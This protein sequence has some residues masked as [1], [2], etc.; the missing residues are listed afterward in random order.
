MEE[1]LA[2]QAKPAVFARLLQA[3][4]DER[5]S[6]VSLL[7]AGLD[8][9]FTASL[10]ADAVADACYAFLRETK[11][12][13]ATLPE[14][15]PDGSAELF[16]QQIKDYEAETQQKRDA[17]LLGKAELTTVCRCRP[18]LHQWEG[19]AAPRQRRRYAGGVRP[20]ARPV[21]RTGRPARGHAKD[22][23]RCAGSRLRLYG[24]RPLRKVRRWWYSS[25]N[26]R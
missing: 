21:W 25:P 20:A 5:L 10:Q 3:P 4:F 1:I 17:G 8:T 15:I 2:G 23:R 6:L 12:A 11:K 16:S 13:L 19:E 9:R 14:D 24:A 18:Q 26:L 7:L 22:R